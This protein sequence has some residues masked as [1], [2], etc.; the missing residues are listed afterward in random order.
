MLELW[1][2]TIVCVCVQRELDGL[3]T[4][5]WAE[6]VF[7]FFFFLLVR[8]CRVWERENEWEMESWIQVWQRKS[9]WWALLKVGE[10]ERESVGKKAK[11]VC[12]ERERGTSQQS[13][14][15]RTNNVE[16]QFLISLTPSHLP[17][18]M[19]AF[20]H[21]FLKL[22][23]FLL[24]STLFF[25]CWSLSEWAATTMQ[26]SREERCVRF[27]STRKCKGAITDA[28]CC[29]VCPS[30]DGRLHDKIS[31]SLASRGGSAAIILITMNLTTINMTFTL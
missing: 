11:N 19:F 16:S 23:S 25:P 28:K 17:P 24:P 9:R 14:E 30:T 12:I 13:C 10:R 7:F 18:F 21:P 5:N 15:M 2:Y 4:P 6:E 26:K 29:S 20:F 8:D 3:H 1:L 22:L 31:Q 27:I